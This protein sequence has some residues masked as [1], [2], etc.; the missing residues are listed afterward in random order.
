MG[1]MSQQE[2]FYRVLWP[3]RA[4]V[5]RTA[6]FLCQDAHEADDLAQEVFVKAFRALDQL[7]DDDGAVRWLMTILRHCRIDRLRASGAHSA[8]S[9]ETAEIDLP[10]E[11]Q[12]HADLS[13]NSAEALL[14]SL[15]DQTIIDALKKLPEEIRWTLLLVDVHGMDHDQAAL[16]QGIPVGT[17]KSR[18][19]RGRAMLRELLMT[20]PRL[21]LVV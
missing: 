1:T 21:R 14:E 17:I 11:R 9:L 20:G 10:D 16:I 2:R 6:R 4:A 18:A 12:A 8:V 7:T 3:H 19:H 5:L 15:S 13:D